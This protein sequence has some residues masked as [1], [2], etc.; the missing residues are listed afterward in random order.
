MHLLRLICA[1]AL[2]A[3][4]VIPARGADDIL[5]AIDQGRKAC[6][7]GAVGKLI[8][9]SG[10]RAIQSQDG[11]VITVVA[12]KFVVQVQGSADAASKLAYANAIDVARLSKM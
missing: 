1:A 7:A 12:N 2:V 5:D 6:L 9:I 3:A 10:L 4:A 8:K 11:N